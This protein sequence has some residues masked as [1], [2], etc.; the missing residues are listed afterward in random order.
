M[1]SKTRQLLYL[2]F[3][4]WHS[5]LPGAAGRKDRYVHA[6]RRAP[7]CL[8]CNYTDPLEASG[9]GDRINSF[10]AVKACPCN[11]DA[12][13]KGPSNPHIINPWDCTWTRYHP[14]WWMFSHG[15]EPPP[16]SR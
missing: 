16:P 11:L 1:Q 8:P 7:R 6:S 9:V 13:C 15:G 4:C 5:Y 10:R 2:L 12:M 3:C 14:G